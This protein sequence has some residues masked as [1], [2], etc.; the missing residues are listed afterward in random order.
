M[1]SYD[2]LVGLLANASDY[3]LLYIIS[4]SVNRLERHMVTPGSETIYQTIKRDGILQEFEDVGGTVLANACGPCIGQWKRFHSG[5]QPR[6]SIITSFS[7][8]GSLIPLLFAISRWASNTD[9]QMSKSLG[10]VTTCCV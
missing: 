8:M 9:G 10:F 6:N 3:F 1:D 2:I 5:E 7:V 4:P